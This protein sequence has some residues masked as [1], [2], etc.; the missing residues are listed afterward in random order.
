MASSASRSHA[1]GSLALAGCAGDDGNNGV[2]GQDGQDFQL[3]ANT[4]AGLLACSTCH[5]ASIGGQR[6]DGKQACD[7]LR[8]FDQQLL[9]RMS[10]PLR[11]HE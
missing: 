6:M 1:G 3:P 10:Q 8:S 7:E 4:E 11:R 5:G 9:N 2:N